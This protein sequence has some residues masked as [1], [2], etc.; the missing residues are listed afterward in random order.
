MVKA[1]WQFGLLCRAESYYTWFTLLAAEVTVE[2]LAGLVFFES[3]Y[4]F[5]ADCCALVHNYS[6]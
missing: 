4:R 5:N 1:A 3:W 2:V 6:F